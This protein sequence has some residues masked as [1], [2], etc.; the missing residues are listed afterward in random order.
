MCCRDQNLAFFVA[1]AKT[2]IVEE[3]SPA[4]GAMVDC[5]LTTKWFRENTNDDAVNQRDMTN[6]W[7]YLQGAGTDS[8]AWQSAHAEVVEQRKPA[9]IV[10][11]ATTRGS[12]QPVWLWVFMAP[13]VSEVK[14][15]LS[16]E[17]RPT[18]F[19]TVMRGVDELHTAHKAR[20]T[21]EGLYS[22]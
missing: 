3:W 5:G 22:L 19:V 17:L 4:C 7:A 2:F 6:L 12:R 20:Q 18:K 10:T 1:D 9:T 11:T 13:L 8:Y 15:P 16:T 14:T 21:V